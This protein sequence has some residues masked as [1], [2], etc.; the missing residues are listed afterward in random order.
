[1]KTEKTGIVKSAIGSNILSCFYHHL[2]WNF[3]DWERKSIMP[4]NVHHQYRKTAKI[5]SQ[6]DKQ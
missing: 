1:M 2:P 4:G 6:H 5:Q 3:N